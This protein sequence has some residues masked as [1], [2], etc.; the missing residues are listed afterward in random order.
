MIDLRAQA[1]SGNFTTSAFSLGQT[2][3]IGSSGVLLSVT[4]PAGKKVRLD[5][6]ATNSGVTESGITLNVDGVD[7]V[8]NA[9]VGYTGN[10]WL[11]GKHLDT[12]RW[13]AMDDIIGNTVTV[14]KVAG[15]TVET[16]FYSYSFGE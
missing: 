11:V 4:A 15:S 8:T 12:A 6:F 7:I 9:S 5:A 2:I 16:L 10:A 14:T 1:Q 13:T 3:A